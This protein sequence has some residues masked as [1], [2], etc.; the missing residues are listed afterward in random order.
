MQSRRGWRVDAKHHEVFSHVWLGTRWY[1]VMG[2]RQTGSAADMATHRF[3]LEA[4]WG[5]HMAVLCTRGGT[6]WGWALHLIGPA[7]WELA[8]FALCV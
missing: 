3:L 1:Y 4:G 8:I 7:S 6:A 5:L 2:V